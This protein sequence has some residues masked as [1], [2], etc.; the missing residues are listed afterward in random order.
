MEG[1]AGRQAGTPTRAGSLIDA[2]VVVISR[3][4]CS[5]THPPTHQSTTPPPPTPPQIISCVVGL[6]SDMEGTVAAVEHF[7]P[8]MAGGQ[9]TVAS[10]MEAGA[11]R[12]V[13]MAVL[14][15]CLVLSLLS[16][17]HGFMAQPSTHTHHTCLP[18]HALGCLV[19][20]VS[21][22]HALLS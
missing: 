6:V 3:V 21:W 16:V 10:A 12:Y 9:A 5:S 7:F 20:P 13:C 18:P 11:N 22:T 15:L 8:W 2:V 17:C 1:L 14:L 19:V 4:P